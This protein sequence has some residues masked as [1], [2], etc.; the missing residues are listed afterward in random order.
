[1]SATGRAV[2]TESASRATVPKYQRGNGHMI[3]A[4]SKT[5]KKAVKPVD[6]RGHM[7]LIE[8][9]RSALTLRGGPESGWGLGELL[10]CNSWVI[11]K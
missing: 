3:D 7:Q 6:P 5:K 2:K 10:W 11:F 9:E 4:A 8:D 1:M